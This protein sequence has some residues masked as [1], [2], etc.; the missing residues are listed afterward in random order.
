MTVISPELERVMRDV[1]APTSEPYQNLRA[2]IES[3]PVLMQQMNM[4]AQQGHLK[5]FALMPA[6]ENAGAS[7]IPATQTINL[8]QEDLLESRQQNKLTFLL[9]HEIQHGLNRE[10]THRG[11][12]QFSQETMQVLKSGQLVHDY[13][14][15]MTHM[16]AA[17]R[18][19]E[20][21]SHIAGWNALVSRVKHKDP[22]ATLTNVAD[23]GR[24]LAY[25]N[26]FVQVKMIEG[27]G[28]FVAKEG[29]IL[30][31]DLSITPDARNIE[32]AATH[33][34]DKAPK[35]TRL[36]HHGNSDYTNYYAASLVGYLCQNEMRNHTQP[37]QL[38]LDMQRLGLQEQ[39]LEQNGIAL[40]DPRAR[41]AYIDARS[42]ET[43]RHF[44]HTVND[45]QHVPIHGL[46]PPVELAPAPRIYNPRE[47][48]HPD[49][50]LYAALK[51]CI[52]IASEQRLA[53]FTAACHMQG[54]TGE[55]FGRVIP[56]E[57]TN[58]VWFERSWPPGPFAKVDLL[59]PMPSQAQMF[60]QV[61][62]YDQEQQAIEQM[63]FQAR[64][65]QMVA[66]QRP[67]MGFP[68][69]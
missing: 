25:V 50:A 62:V 27:Q 13:S 53:Q 43:V 2:V 68:M 22:N 67:S 61:Q 21:S 59:A 39:L 11:L 15:A 3:S 32:S 24:S 69:R 65:E 10:Q 7:Y 28:Q 38:T 31:P 41:C 55:N 16:L 6:S 63:R 9:G 64:Q 20:A 19:D 52:P 54:I 56:L 40:T 44:D 30:N 49:H 45:H 66:Q 51:E 47:P 26:D 5:H 4:A 37:G 36:G 34:F 33:Y 14:S 23:V 1:G 46:P 18:N 60:Q 29:L 8:R 57:E 42:P 17:H 35:E 48:D 58:Q 12:E